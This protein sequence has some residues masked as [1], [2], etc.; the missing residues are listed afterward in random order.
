MVYVKELIFSLALSKSLVVVDSFTKKT[1]LAT[2]ITKINAIKEY[3]NF[4]IYPISFQEYF[5]EIIVP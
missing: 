2:Q 1:A 4:F 5:I 3:V